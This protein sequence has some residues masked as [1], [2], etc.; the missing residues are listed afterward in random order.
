[1]A[2]ITASPKGQSANGQPAGNRC[3]FLAGN[4]DFDFRLEIQSKIRS[5]SHEHI[6]SQ[7][8]GCTSVPF[9]AK[10]F[11]FKL[12]RTSSSFTYT[13]R[14]HEVRTPAA[15]S[16]LA[17]I[18]WRKPAVISI[19]L[20]KS[21]CDGKSEHSKF[22][23]G[24]RRNLIKQMQLMFSFMLYYDLGG[25]NLCRVAEAYRMMCCI[26]QGYLLDDSIQETAMLLERRKPPISRCVALSI[27]YQTHSSCGSGN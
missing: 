7:P 27:R 4:S 21:F 9:E 12:C 13:C 2:F 20:P 18:G 11:G 14:V 1:M 16:N 10:S 25:E 26:Q 17:E 6:F 22:C 24:Q 8:Y 19:P 15:Q 3:D 23:L 5:Y